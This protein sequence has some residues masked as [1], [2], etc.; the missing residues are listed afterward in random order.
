MKK[1]VVIITAALALSACHYGKQEAG[2]SL[3][4]NK[5]YKEVKAGEPSTEI[6][7]DY[8]KNNGG[9]GAT[10]AAADTA[11]PAAEEAPAT[12]AAH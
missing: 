2:A 1:I 11:K 5:E 12:P 6:N 7:P 9:S 4:R 8:V 10:V 3:E